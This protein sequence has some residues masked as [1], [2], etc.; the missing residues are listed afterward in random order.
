M[1][2]LLAA[3]LL[4][5]MVADYPLQTNWMA[6]NKHDSVDALLQHSAVHALCTFAF[7]AVFTASLPDAAACSSLLFGLHAVI[8]AQN[9][10]IR[11]DQTAHLSWIII[12]AVLFP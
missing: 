11:W 1:Y 7:V 12:V 10:P 3:L 5:H 4:S 2:E 9:L 8:D 6:E